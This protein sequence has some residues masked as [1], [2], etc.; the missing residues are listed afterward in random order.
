[1]RFIALACMGMLVF[2]SQARADYVARVVAANGVLDG[3][4]YLALNPDCTLLGYPTVKV[5]NTPQNGEIFVSK[6]R[7]FPFYRRSNPRSVCNSRRAPSMVLR[8]RPHRGFVGSDGFAVDVI[9]PDGSERN[10]NYNITV[11]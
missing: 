9:F 1:M 6:V 8:Y 5:L 11:K 7:S 4:Y 10:D 2:A 3:L